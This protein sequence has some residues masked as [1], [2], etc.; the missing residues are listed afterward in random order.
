M[1]KKMSIFAIAFCSIILTACAPSCTPKTET[2]IAPI[3]ENKT[4]TQPAVSGVKKKPIQNTGSDTMVN[5]AQAWSEEF[6]KIRPDISVE[7]SGPGS[8]AGIASMTNGTADLVNS[9]RKMTP[10]EIAQCKSNNNGKEPKEFMVGYDGLAVYIHK[11]N[12]INELTLEQLADIYKKGGMTEK[13][14]QLGVDHKKLCPSDEIVRFSRMSNSGTYQY[15]REA[16]LQKGDFKLGSKDLNGSKE[17]VDA[18]GTTPCGIGYSGMAYKTNEVKFVKVA[19]KKGDPSYSPTLETVLS[20]EYPISRPLF[21]YTL[22]EPTGDLKD[23]V[24]WILS[25]A[26]QQLIEKIGYIPLK[27][28]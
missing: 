9:S 15:F 8:A 2:N 4:A 12:P 13:W 7:V 28:K 25:P 3:L 24:D 5:V 6:R 16:V 26:G 14:S 17:V 10:A 22:G 11:D 23:Y 18:T 19:K 21:L 27:K 20:G 1:D